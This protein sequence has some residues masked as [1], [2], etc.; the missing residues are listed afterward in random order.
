MYNKMADKESSEYVLVFMIQPLTVS[1]TAQEFR[2]VDLPFF[3][4]GNILLKFYGLE[5]HF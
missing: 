5:M 2:G 4:E 1:S 3:M